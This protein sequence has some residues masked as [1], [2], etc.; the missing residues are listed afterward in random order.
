MKKLLLA[1]CLLG[2]LGSHALADTISQTI[3]VNGVEVTGKLVTAIDFDGDEATLTYSDG[4]AETASMEEINILFSYGTNTPT[5]TE[6][7]R[8]FSFSGIVGGQLRISG[9]EDGTAVQVFDM[10]GKAVAS[11]LAAEGQVSIDVATL[12]RGVYVARAGKE[13]IKFIKK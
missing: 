12:G 5:A 3:T 6:E 10:T 2:G 11:A 4:S 7:V 1:L 8:V 13:A 9:L